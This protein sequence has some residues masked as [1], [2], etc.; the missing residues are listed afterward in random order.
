MG[1][2]VICGDSFSIGIGCVDLVNDAWGPLLGKKYD[3]E[4]LNLAKG[5]STNYSIY[6]QAEAAVKWEDDIDLLI[7]SNT[8][9]H[10]VNFFKEKEHLKRSEDM[11]G[12]P[13]PN[14]LDVNY[15]EYPPYGEGTYPQ[16]IPHPYVNNPNYRGNLNTENWHGVISYTDDIKNTKIS[17]YYKKFGGEEDRPMLLR[18]YYLEVFDIAI[19]AQYDAAIL[20]RAYMEAKK[21]NIPTLL[22]MDIDAVQSLVPEEDFVRVSWGNLALEYPDTLKTF[23]TSEEGHKSAF[24]STAAHIDRY[25][26]L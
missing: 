1:K 19:Q 6:L 22:A 4:V 21:A 8:C 10:R 18:N 20:L 5:S 15:H 9:P 23:H 14:N 24:E 3:R 12:A 25:N 13:P 16:I 26:L 11:W 7:I 2:I 17:S